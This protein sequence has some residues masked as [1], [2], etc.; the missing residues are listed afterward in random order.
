LGAGAS[1]ST[2]EL[3]RLLVRSV[4]SV[5]SFVNLREP[6]PTSASQSLVLGSLLMCVRCQCALGIY[7]GQV[8]NPG[9]AQVI[10]TS[11]CT[12]V[13]DCNN[14]HVPGMLW[15]RDFFIGPGL[16]GIKVEVCQGECSQC[17]ANLKIGCEED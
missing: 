7:F 10:E 2:V 8:L 4:L 11:F 16:R 9:T 13:P 5:G 6:G 3:L 15:Q 14:M 12:S 1:S 17:A